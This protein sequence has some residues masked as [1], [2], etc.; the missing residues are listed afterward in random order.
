MGEIAELPS[1]RATSVGPLPVEDP[2]DAAA[3]ALDAGA[4]FPTVPVAAG[5][6]R[7]LLAQAVHG[8]DG[9][10]LVP[11]GRLEVDPDR[12][13]D[14]GDLPELD[15]LDGAPFEALHRFLARRDPASED[16]LR[17][18][19]PGPVTVA[20]QLLAAG[21][22]PARATAGAACVVRRRSVA[23]LAAVR[24]AA[25]GAPVAVVLVE[26]GLVGAMHPTF[27]LTPGSL[28]DLLDPVVADLD[29]ADRTG[30]LVIGVHVPGRTDWGT[31]MDAGVSLVSAP[32]DTGLV[33]WADRVGEFLD[34]GGR[35]A[36]GAVP[37]DRPLGTSEQRLWRNL[38]EVWGELVAVGV[39][40][41]LVRERSLVSPADG[42]AHF[43][44]SQAGR[45]LDLTASLA[46]RVQRQALAARLP[47]GA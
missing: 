9:I 16:P 5:L 44:R 27:P 17:L 13:P 20:V 47:I 14:G 33:G 40:P 46:A 22:G 2:E 8:V 31:V 6:E 21:L 7:S 12:L 32:A 18:P 11:P 4:G 19:V 38:A 28:R 25:P 41:M 1:G 36:W 43:G 35:V 23:M 45:V 39:D 15:R 37:V 3:L 42:L 24:R 30:S 10:R 26:P 34:A 29:G